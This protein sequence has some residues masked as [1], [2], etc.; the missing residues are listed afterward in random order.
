[1]LPLPGLG[2]R[3]H[4]LEWFCC[5]NKLSE[6]PAVQPRTRDLLYSGF[7]LAVHAD[8]VARADTRLELETAAP[9][10]GG[11]GDGGGGGGGDGHS[12]GHKPL[13]E[14]RVAYLVCGLCAADLGE[15]RDSLVHLWAHVVRLESNLQDPGL[16]LSKEECFNMIIKSQVRD[17][18]EKMPKFFVRN[19]KGNHTLLWIMDRSLTILQTL[20][21]VVCQKVVLKVLYKVIGD[22]DCDVAKNNSLEI[23]HLS[24]ELYEAGLEEMEKSTINLPESFRVVNGYRC[25]YIYK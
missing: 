5:V 4:S 15:V 14:E 17:S 7:S 22:D 8:T 25:A 6:P 12:C 23:I 16:S 2:W 10:A 21:D 11:D 1:M 19:R 24:D 18:I 13:Q 9:G 20:D 3:T